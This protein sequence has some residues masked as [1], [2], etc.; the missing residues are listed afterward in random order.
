MTTAVSFERRG[1]RYCAAHP[2]RPDR[3]PRLGLFRYRSPRQSLWPTVSPSSTLRGV[4]PAGC[5]TEF[6]MRCS[7][8]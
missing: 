7:S 3:R 4:G 8:R 1:R 6:E 2:Q 5:C